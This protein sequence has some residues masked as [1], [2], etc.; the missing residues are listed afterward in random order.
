MCFATGSLQAQNEYDVDKIPAELKK[1]ATAVVRNEQVDLVVRSQSSATMVY[2]TA[3]TILSKS[4]ED[5]A[6]MSEYYDKFSSVYNLKASMY[7]AKGVKIKNYKSADFKD[8]SIISDGTLF[9]DSRIKE[10]YFLNA[11]YPFTIEYSYEKDF[12]GYLMFPSWTPVSAYDVAVEQS[13][14]SLK[15]PQEIK[16]KFLS[17]KLSKTDSSTVN[18]TVNYK[19]AVKNFP[20]AEYEPMSVGL[21]DITPWVKATPNKFEYDNSRGSVESWQALGSWIYDLSK[22]VQ[23][24]PEA[25]K[26]KVRALVENAKTDR[27]KINILYKYLQSNT[28]YVSVQLGLGGFKPIAAEKVAAVIMVTARPCRIT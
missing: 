12:N 10:L 6:S 14:Y 5:L 26:T 3:I 15:V 17:S 25:T 24:L 7:D 2:K 4:S 1:G 21:K 19:W 11:S 8:R 16:I 18:R 27:E 28:R 9:D 20:A 23:R 22:D 13:S